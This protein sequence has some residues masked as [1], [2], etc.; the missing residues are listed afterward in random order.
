[1]ARDRSVIPLLQSFSELLQ[2]G[3]RVSWLKCHVNGPVKRLKV[4]VYV[5]GIADLLD[6]VVGLGEPQARL[7]TAVVEDLDGR[8]H[9]GRRSVREPLEMQVH[10]R[11]PTHI[12]EVDQLL[13]PLV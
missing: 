8:E 13:P 5:L 7:G 4:A 6:S 2:V 3:G 11:T 9:A 12:S 10:V 1:M